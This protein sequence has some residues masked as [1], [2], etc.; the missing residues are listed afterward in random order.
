MMKSSQPSQLLADIEIPSKSDKSPAS[1]AEIKPLVS[2][3]DKVTVVIAKA[4]SKSKSVANKGDSVTTT[5]DTKAAPHRA[6][7]ISASSEGESPSGP[8]SKMRRWSIAP[9]KSAV[10]YDPPPFNPS[11]FIPRMSEDDS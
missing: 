8:A 6:P 10:F 11:D 4:P 1:K 3:T 7:S 9:I 5:V 2:K